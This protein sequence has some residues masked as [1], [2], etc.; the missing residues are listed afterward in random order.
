[1][2]RAG[3]SGPLRVSSCPMNLRIRSIRTL[4]GFRSAKPF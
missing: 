1:L 3:E 2:I 4:F